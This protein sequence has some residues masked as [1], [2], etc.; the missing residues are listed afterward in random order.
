MGD[1]YKAVN[2]IGLFANK[3]HSDFEPAGLD[4]L[5]SWLNERTWEQ[6]LSNK[7]IDVSYY[8]ELDQVKFQYRPNEDY[9]AKYS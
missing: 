8:K 2:D 6:Y 3:F 5:E 4:C 7:T 9:D 1:I